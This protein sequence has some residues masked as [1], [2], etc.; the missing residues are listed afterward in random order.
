VIGYDAAARELYVDRTRS[1]DTS[2]SPRFASV[3]R[4][5]LE[6]P[7]SGHLRLR[8]LV[9][10][11]SVEVFADRGRRVITDQVF[12]SAGSDRVQLFAEGGRASARTLR[13]WQMQSIWHPDDQAD[14]G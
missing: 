14:G 2:F 1:G 3:S 5:P 13:L 4:A 12:P 7:R 10:H 9:D 11:S 8:V 6:L